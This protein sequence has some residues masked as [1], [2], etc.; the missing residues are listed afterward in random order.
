VSKP[1]ES[2]ACYLC[3][4]CHVI[5]LNINSLDVLNLLSTNRRICVSKMSH[6]WTF[7][8]LYATYLMCNAYHWVLREELYISRTFGHMKQGARLCILWDYE[9]FLTAVHNKV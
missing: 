5:R 9:A 4:W 7:T 6:A 2:P 3:R 8:P 1:G